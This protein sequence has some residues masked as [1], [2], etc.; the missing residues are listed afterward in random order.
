MESIISAINDIVWSNALIILCLGAGI[1]FSIATR[2]LQV[3]YIREMIRLLFNGQSSKKGVSSF[4]AFSIAIAG[5]VGTGNIAGVATAIAMGGPGA[6][7]WMWVIAFLG[8]SSAFIEAT[9][10]QIY[11]QVKDGEYRGGPAYY[12][13]KGLGMKWYAVVFAV[14]TIVSMALFLPGVQS[15]SIASSMYTAFEVPTA[16]TGAG[17][18]V[19]LAL[20]IFGGVKRIG[21]VA[22]VAVPFMAGAYILM[23]LIIIV[24]NI[25]E[26][27]AVISLIVSSAF[28]AEPAFAGMFGMA[29]SWGVKR[30]IYS[31]E[32]GQGTAPHAA[33]AAE[34]SHPAKQGLVQA[35]SVYVDTLFVCTATAFMILFTGQYN[36]VNPEGGFVVENLPGIAYGPEY[37][38]Q[39]VNTFFPSLGSGFVAVSLL[40]FAFTTIMAYYYIAETNL[41]YLNAKGN[42]WLLWVLRALILAATF[43][44]S[45]KTA[46]SAWML[47][48]IGVG[49]MA[50]LNVVAIL[51]LRKPAL[52]ALKDYQAQRKAG[53]DP[54]YNAQRLGIPNAGEW[55]GK[56]LEEKKLQ[57]A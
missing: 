50:W 14:A 20:I 2:F 29:I 48:D 37:T 55:D 33:A 17:V 34:V 53:L 32:A 10:G 43:Y 42:K 38:Q 40:L 22:E 24:A 35:F 56:E 3:R 23:T 44:G 28:D 54:V 49:I 39:A 30:G 15:N 6:V 45:I 41:S 9:L 12:I 1:Y 31:N 21:K 11:K 18:T 19:L 52:Q 51:L 13:E 8:S 25:A 26:V 4:Q 57:Q 7:F 16:A 5:R 27:P 47:G 36:V 46:E